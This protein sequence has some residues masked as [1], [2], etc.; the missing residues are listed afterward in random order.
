[1]FSFTVLKLVC[2]CA[3]LVACAMSIKDPYS[4]SLSNSSCFLGLCFEHIYYNLDFL[5]FEYK[6]FSARR[7]QKQFSAFQLYSFVI[8]YSLITFCKVKVKKSAFFVFQVGSVFD[9]KIQYL[10]LCSVRQNWHH[11]HEVFRWNWR[12]SSCWMHSI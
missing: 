9:L 5:A 3:C 11:Q 12:V 2:G 6:L 8:P 10:W 4:H 7:H 1:M